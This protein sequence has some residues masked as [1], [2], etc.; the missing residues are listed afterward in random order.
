MIRFPSDVDHSALIRV[1]LRVYTPRALFGALYR[2][3]DRLFV[4]VARC[5]AHA[6]DV[7]LTAKSG[8]MDAAA[9][10]GEFAN[11]LADEVL[12]CAIAEETQPVRELLVAEA[13][14]AAEVFDRSGADADYESDPRGIAS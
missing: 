14:A 5:D 13:F 3:T 2:F 7:H 1:D 6:V 9:L 11:A 8:G 10:A 12:R 4:Y